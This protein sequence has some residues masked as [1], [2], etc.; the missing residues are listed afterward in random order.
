MVRALLK[1]L[2]SVGVLLVSFAMVWSSLY[3]VN[4]TALALGLNPLAG[5]YYSVL[6]GDALGFFLSVFVLVYFTIPAIL[7]M[8]GHALAWITH[9]AVKSAKGLSAQRISAA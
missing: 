4:L 3:T 7:S 6:F 9:V 8:F 2:V 1:L 5:G